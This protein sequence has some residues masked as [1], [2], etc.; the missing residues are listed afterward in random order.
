MVTGLPRVTTELLA[1]RNFAGK[2]RMEGPLITKAGAATVCWPLPAA[3]LAASSAAKA[4]A[5]QRR[6]ENS[7]APDGEREQTSDTPP[8]SPALRSVRWRTW[9]RELSEP[10]SYHAWPRS[11][12]WIRR[13]YNS[14]A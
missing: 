10:W 11:A 6:Y 2:W 1:L 9:C 7:A 3:S 5:N 8:V 13:G 14:G 4:L 12:G